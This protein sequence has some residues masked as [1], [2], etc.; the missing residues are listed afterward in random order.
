M[1]LGWD[2]GG[3]GSLRACNNSTVGGTNDPGYFTFAGG[4]TGDGATP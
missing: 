4:G 2:P 1:C 3:S